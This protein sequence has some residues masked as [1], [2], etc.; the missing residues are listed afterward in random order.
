MNPNSFQD[1]FIFKY[2]NSLKPHSSEKGLEGIEEEKELVLNSEGTGE[3]FLHI[4]NY[5]CV[6]IHTFHITD[7]TEMSGAIKKKKKPSPLTLS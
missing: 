1:L 2:K 7:W 6:K 3:L 5:L 4:I